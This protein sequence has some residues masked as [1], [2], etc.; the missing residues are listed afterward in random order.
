MSKISFNENWRFRNI[1]FENSEIISLPHDAMLFESRSEN[2]N[3]GS[4]GAFFS[5]GIY[6]YSKKF[7]KESSWENKK[8][9]IEFEGVFKDASVSINNNIVGKIENGYIHHK[10]DITDFLRDS[11]NDIKIVVENNDH[12]NSRWYT[13]S[14]IYR[15]VWLYILPQ[16]H[17]DRDNVKITTESINPVIV[18]ADAGQNVNVSIF[19]TNDE[20]IYH[21]S[22]NDPIQLEDVSLWSSDNPYLYTFRFELESNGQLEDAYEVKTGLR[23]LS[24]STNGFTVNGITT[25]LKGA[26]IH[27]DNGIVGAITLKELEYRKIKKLKEMGFNAVRASHNP[28]SNY[29]IEACDELGMYF[30]DETWDYWYNAKSK[31]DYSKH[32]EKNYIYDISTMIKRDYN[33]PSVIMYSIG[34]EISEPYDKKGLDFAD[35]LITLCKSMDSTRAVT[36]GVN[37]MVLTSASKGKGIYKEDGGMRED[38]KSKEKLTSSTLFNL[39]TYFVGTGMNKSS[40]SEKSNRI[41]KPF[42]DKLD[43]AGYNY[44]SGR[45]KMEARKNPNRIVFGS[46]TFPQ[47]LYKNWKLVEKLP[48]LIGDF[49]WTGWDYLG[50]C[51][52]GSWSY[53]PEGRGFNKPYPWLLAEVGVF[54]ILGYPG[55]SAYY[56]RTVWNTDAKSYVGVRP[57]KYGNAKVNKSVWRSTNAIDSWSWRDCDGN[58]TVV[59]VYSRGKNVTL[60][61]NNINAGKKSFRKYKANF[62]VKYSKGNMKAKIEHHDGSI[63]IIELFSSDQELTYKVE[64]EQSITGT[65]IDVL[66]LSV[67]DKDGIVESNSDDEF[68]LLVDGADL[69]GFGSAQPITESSFTTGKYES[70]YGRAQAII[71]HNHKP[72]VI[73]VKSKK[74]GD[75]TFSF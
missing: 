12:P 45:Y 18:K 13:G 49:M 20:L 56:A 21:G 59:E 44:T 26:C 75:K 5:G 35:K 22:T 74:Y 51:G 8:V 2:N 52:I 73:K 48:Y 69:L 3:S 67:V 15:P 19:G 60:F 66:N 63:E 53:I 50:E 14:G 46:E 65:E 9:I 61:I 40:N 43:I 17:I 34:N 6:E 29:L 33:H 32:I 55:A 42:L 10:F 58:P 47:D 36:C 27:H 7:N 11:E 38:S 30:I 72:Y 31:N 57:A 70:H 71:R 54:D 41:T 24:W 68:E 16:N 37:L 62:K 39:I 25:K 4:A 23:V 1:E 64:R 28:M